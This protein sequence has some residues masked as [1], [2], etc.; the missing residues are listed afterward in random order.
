MTS[1]QGTLNRSLILV[2][3]IAFVFLTYVCESGAQ[4][5]SR[6]SG[7]PA[8]TV[9]PTA[10]P[11]QPLLEDR[12]K[13]PTITP[14]TD[15]VVLTAPP[16]KPTYQRRSPA[17]VRVAQA[18]RLESP[19]ARELRNQ[20]NQQRSFQTGVRTR[21]SRSRALYNIRNEQKQKDNQTVEELLEEM[22]RAAA[23]TFTQP[24][25]TISE[26]A[27]KETPAIVEPL[28]EPFEQP[29]NSSDAPWVDQPSAW[30]SSSTN[31]NPEIEFQSSGSA[32]HPSA[33]N[34]LS[35]DLSF[36]EFLA[37]K[38]HPT[39]NASLSRILTARHEALQ[40][41]LPPN[42]NLGLFIDEAGNENDPGLWGAY[43][44]RK[45]IRGNKLALGREIKNREANVLEVEFET[46]A[47]RIRTDVRTAFYKL[48][49][50][51]EKMALMS[52]LF[53]TQQQAVAK[54]H[55]LFDAGETPRTDVLQTELQ[56]QRTQVLMSQLEITSQTA[57]REL[58]SV[59][60][61]PEIQPREVSGDLNPI[62]E[63]VSFEECRNHILAHSP[64][65]QSAQ[66][67]MDRIRWTIEREIAETVPDYQTQLTVGRD[68]TTNHFFTGLQI[69]IPLQ[70]CDQNQG[71]IAAA[72][73]RLVT[74]QNELERI[75]LDLSKRLSSEY[76]QYESALAKTDMYLNQLLPKSQETLELLQ[77]GYPSDVSFLQL[78]VAQQAVID[79]ALEYL[80]TLSLV[81]ESRL[82]IEGLLLDDSLTK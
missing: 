10:S 29:S 20:L 75:K 50:V 54:A 72:K 38:N 21:P 81:W 23:P 71:N 17:P 5:S 69:Q 22:D 82:K 33:S 59:V 47:T 36:F 61:D 46:Q 55:Q 44:Q 66:A 25:T 32:L 41:G 57:W 28:N 77:Q 30:N 8:S 12:S 67:E 49:I 15:N 16:S 76:R 14:V 27:T 56:L 3:A 18:N 11:T 78:S 39:L 74:A 60:G 37:I 51:K 62:V 13:H 43:L 26:S 35:N 2:C 1:R 58:A 52:Q 40:A 65:L 31:Q 34:G 53:Q 7:N 80:D 48:L 24:N 6:R 79:I 68:S 73:S 70:V 63:P 64:E 19:M 45:H 4:S 9:S 42:P